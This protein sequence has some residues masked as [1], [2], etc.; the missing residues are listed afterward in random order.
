MRGFARLPPLP[1]LSSCPLGLCLGQSSAS[2]SPF[3]PVSL[4]LPPAHP[5]TGGDDGT[6]SYSHLER[7]GR[8]ERKALTA[9]LNLYWRPLALALRCNTL[10]GFWSPPALRF[11]RRGRLFEKQHST[12]QRQRTKSRHGLLGVRVGEAD[13]PAPPEPCQAAQSGARTPP[14]LAEDGAA[15]RRRVAVELD[16]SNA[17]VRSQ[18]ASLVTHCGLRDGPLIPQCDTT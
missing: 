15:V 6:H 5:Q 2:A 8:R 3:P 11:R 1:A 18:G 7:I 16:P 10:C 13:I 17:F 9:T 4:L 12:W 14:Q